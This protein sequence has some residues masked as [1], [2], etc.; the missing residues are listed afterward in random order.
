MHSTDDLE[1]GYFGSGK[2]L[3]YSINKHGIENHKVEILEFAESRKALK[4]RE[5]ELVNE[6]LLS[7]PLNMNLKFGGEG[8]WDHVNKGDVWL[9]FGNLKN[10]DVYDKTRLAQKQ[11]YL[12]DLEYQS[13]VKSQCSKMNQRSM[14]NNPNGT[15]FGK[16]HSEETKEKMRK[17]KNA[18]ESN[19]QFGTCWIHKEA[20]VKKVQKEDLQLWLGKGWKKGRKEERLKLRSSLI[21]RAPHFD[22][23]RR[24]S[25]EGSNP[26]SVA[27]FQ[28]RPCC[29]GSA[30]LSVKQKVPDRNRSVAPNLSASQWMEI[31]LRRKSLEVRILSCGPTTMA[32]VAQW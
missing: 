27:Q 22:C 11:R 19:S 9:G 18:G 4:K 14:E 10:R 12:T 20:A 7:N 1:D 30:S 21:G 28:W 5:A 2:I 6:E 16:Q 8:G 32:K 23:G 25:R 15:F 13:Q 17:T 3:N 31:S 29:S 24:K 26:S